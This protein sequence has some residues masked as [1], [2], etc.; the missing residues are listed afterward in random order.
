M[1]SVNPSLGFYSHGFF[2]IKSEKAIRTQILK[3]DL[4]SNPEL[5]ASSEF[6]GDAEQVFHFLIPRYL[7]DLWENVKGTNTFFAYVFSFKYLSYKFPLG[8][9]LV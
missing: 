5:G 2:P 6:S 3:K 7:S 1:G 8:I 9:L 4:K